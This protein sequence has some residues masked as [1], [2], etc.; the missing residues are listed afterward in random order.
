MQSKISVAL[1]VFALVACNPSQKV[2]KDEALRRVEEKAA[3]MELPI[4]SRSPQIETKEA[5]FRITYPL[6]K[7]NNVRGGDWI[8]VIDRDTGDFTD[9][10]IYR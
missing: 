7:A 5:S 6:P 2:T 8:F 9:I 1:V 10:K 4:Q 3:K